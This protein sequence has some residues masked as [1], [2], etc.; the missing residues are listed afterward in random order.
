MININKWGYEVEGNLITRLAMERG[1]FIP[2]Q[3]FGIGLIIVVAELI[4]K[5]KQIIYISIS[6]L[7]L[8]TSALNFYC[9]L[10]IK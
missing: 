5:Y 6:S 9:Y 8:L 10:F 4:P 1:L 3:V 2:A 7:S